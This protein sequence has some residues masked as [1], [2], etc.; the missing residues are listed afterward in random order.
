MVNILLK[1]LAA[2]GLFL[3]TPII[4]FSLLL[5]LIEDGFPLFF[6]QD[7]LGFNKK[8]F[9]I[10]KI[11]TMYNNTPSL[12]THDISDSHYLRIGHILRRLKIDELPQVV[13]F[14]KGDI[15]LIGPR[16]GLPSQHELTKCRTKNNIF[17]IVP[18]ISGLSQVLGYDMSN[19]SLL[20]KIDR[21][22]INRKSAK[23]DIT[24]FIATF[25]KAYRHKLAMNFKNEILEYKKEEKL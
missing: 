7:R 9:K 8:V 3:L 1:M 10:Y 21:L 24:I 15:N 19:P 12:G 4:A 13:N 23:L 11:R 20:S 16:P 2:F 5:V 6:I 18:G 25:Y 17:K 22:Y 14:I